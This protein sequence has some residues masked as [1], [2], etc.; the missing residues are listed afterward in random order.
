MNAI[1]QLANRIWRYFAH[2][3][4]IDLGTA[5]TLVFVLGKG[6]VIRE[7]STVAIH[8]KT[9]DVL[10]IGAEAKRMV[11]KTPA[12]IVAIRPL[13]GGVIS[14][15]DVAEA[16]LNYFIRKV[17]RTRTITNL[18]I[19]KPRVAIGIPSG[20]TEV[21]RKAVLDATLRAGARQVYLIEEPMAAAIGAGL[22]VEE[23]TGN[24]IV[25][26]GG[27]TAEIAVISLG[28]IVNSRSI[29]IAG[30]EFDEQ[31]I[32][33][34]KTKHNLL[35]GEKTAEDTKIAIGTALPAEKP[36]DELTTT[37][38]GRDLQSG[39]PREIEIS[40][41]ELLDALDSPLRIIIENIKETIEETPPELISDLH[42]QGIVLT[43]GGG[44][45]KRF[46][47]RISREANIPVRTDPD[48]LTTVVRGC[49]KALEEIAPLDKVQIT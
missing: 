48:P 41:S 32:N 46:G 6:I 20:V 12:N 45:L 15:F 39:L 21:E 1:D 43:G 38:R 18:K 11:G 35:I 28:G 29:R 17:H 42:H 4:A 25:D 3:I 44:L 24:M 40:G 26:I 34:A 49:G 19:P 31:I 47:E 9:R 22:P 5:N 10:A 36:E 13:R 30:D 33:W 14:D 16:M 7:P 23:P 37:I 2:D 27:G 8:K